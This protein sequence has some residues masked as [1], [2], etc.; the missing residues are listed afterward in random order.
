MSELWNILGPELVLIGAACALFFLG[1]SGKTSARASAPWLALLA[2]LGVFA[3]QMTR[4]TQDVPGEVH[5]TIGSLRM[6]PLAQYIRLLT[7]VVAIMLLLLAWPTREDATGNSALDYGQD[8]GEFFAM[9]LLSIAGVLLV[10]I[11]NDLVLL[12]LALELVSLPTYIMVSMSRPGAAAQ[13][14]GVKYFF[15]G[16][17]SVALMLFGFSYLYGTTG[18]INLIKIWF[19]LRPPADTPLAL[20]VLSP[21]QMMAVVMILVGLAYK[22]AAF[23]LHFYAGDVYEGAATPVTAFLAFVPKTAGFVA[24]VKVLFMVGG[25]NFAVP[26]QILALLWIMAALTMTIGNVLALLQNNVKRVLAYSSIAHSGYMLAGIAALCSS[27]GVGFDPGTALRGVLFYLAA[28]GI[29][30]GGAFGVLVLLPSR[31]SPNESAETFEDLAGQGRRRT[32]LGL[33]MAVSCFSLIGIPATVGFLGK[34][35][36]ILPTFA[37]GLKWL[38]VV[39]IINAAISA[40]Y[41]LRIVASMFLRTESAAGAELQPAAAARPQFA[42]VLAVVLSVV[43]TLLFGAVPQAAQVLTVGAGQGANLYVT[44]SS[45]PPVNTAVAQ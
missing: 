5:T 8:A 29:M 45:S 33:A 41:Y 11:A 21:W 15:L 10:S 32:A 25:N 19:K 14:A 20:V 6:D 12:F 9:F 31:V 26:K 23:P 18:E 35:M 3:L 39:L 22:M 17:L 13:E 36:L 38:V 4:Y 28:Y 40:A 30:N 37:A 27:A 2:L 7:P 16:A 43:G 34:L 24:L 44:P 1:C 42:V